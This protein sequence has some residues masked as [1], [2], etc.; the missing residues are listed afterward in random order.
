MPVVDQAAA[1]S[2]LSLAAT[3]TVAPWAVL[4]PILI[5][6]STNTGSKLV[7]ACVAAGPG[8]DLPVAAGLCSIDCA[9]WAPWLWLCR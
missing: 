4:I 6:S 3:S 8:Y 2:M 1:A 5:A 7:G 9:P